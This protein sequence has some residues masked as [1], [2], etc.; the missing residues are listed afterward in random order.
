MYDPDSILAWLEENVESMRRSRAKTLSAI[1]GSA[2]QMQ[3][4]GVLAFDGKEFDPAALAGD[5]PQ[6]LVFQ[7]D[8]RVGLRGLYGKEPWR[9]HPA[10]N[11]S[12]TLRMASSKEFVQEI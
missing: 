9:N 2:M 7:D 11:S 12:T 3:G 1:V 4:T 10:T 5:K 6:V 8:S